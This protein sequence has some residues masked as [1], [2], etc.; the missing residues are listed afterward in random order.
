MKKNDG[1]VTNLV[2]V[3]HVDHGK[4][5]LLGRLLMD[6]KSLP[7]QKYE[8]VKKICKEKGKEF[9]YAY[10][11]DGLAEEQTQGITIDITHVNFKCRDRVFN[12]IDAPGHK[13]FLK[14]MISGV[15]SAN[16]ALL[17]VDAREGIREQTKRHVYILSLIGVKQV[18]VIVNKM[19]LVRYSP[20]VFKFIKEKLSV[21]LATLNICPI[22]YIPV[23]SKKG[24]NIV[25]KSKKMPWFGGYP[26]LKMLNK[27]SL[28]QDKGDLPFRLPVQD[29]YKFDSERII[30]G[31]IESGRLKSGDSIYVWPQDI[32]T[33]VKKI[34]KW[35]P[36]SVK[37]SG[38]AG[39]SIGF[40]VK[41]DIFVDRG[42]VI[43]HEGRKPFI[44]NL[45][46]A[47]IFWMGKRSLA[48]NKKYKIKLATQEVDCELFS[49]NKV[50]D[51]VS[52]KNLPLA[53]AIS[54]NDVADVTLKTKSALCFDNFNFVPEVGRFVLVD[55]FD[56]AGGGIIT[57]GEYS[58][59]RL[60]EKKP[61][62]ED[63]SVGVTFV[64]QKEREKRLGQKGKVIWITGL[65]G[66]GKRRIG[67]VLE[68]K[69][70]D[71][72]RSTFLLEGES[73]RLG[74]SSDLGFGD[75]ERTEQARRVAEV[76][77]LFKR[78]GMYMIVCL[79]SP[80]KKDRKFARKLVGEDNF[81]EIFI[82]TPLSVCEER[83]PHGIYS[84]SGKGTAKNVTGMDSAY[85]KPVNPDIKI[86]IRS[87][88]F[89]AGKV[90]NKIL[91]ELPK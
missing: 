53:E 62:S 84:K 13:Q 54:K 24:E 63:V 83:D 91:C 25:K 85:E 56:I 12:I 57:E 1:R 73:I 32:K 15:A 36:E 80:F 17:L 23:S 88:N 78:A 86:N 11:L 67:R 4:S 5:T 44:S 74:L 6:T 79:I 19:D 65:P 55:G 61:K 20:K 30:A 43:T 29:V 18:I 7:R 87:A 58:D 37:N 71:M 66:S 42:N 68:R 21:F 59:G 89:D 69:L 64:A 9:E 81:V 34:K 52:L 46:N 70:F 33:V 75:E 31:R 27:F 60:Y 45:F 50:I 35:R 28:S 51:A 16:A 72:G 77:N 2:I 26:L 8:L 22:D 47:H 14:N 39:E 49:V 90:A 10:L 38:I 48:K 41:D 82:D 76:A 40:T 3:G